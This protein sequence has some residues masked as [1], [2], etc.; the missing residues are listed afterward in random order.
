MRYQ[1]ALH[2]ELFNNDVYN[3]RV[4]IHVVDATLYPCN[5]DG[6]HTRRR[7]I[8][9]LDPKCM[10]IH[11]ADKQLLPVEVPEPQQA[12]GDTRQA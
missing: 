2:S 11:I 3:I 10:R 6:H 9:Q 4:D 1:A 5:N 7:K 8:L 12:P